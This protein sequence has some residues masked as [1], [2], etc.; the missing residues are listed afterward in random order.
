MLLHG[1]GEGASPIFPVPALDIVEV[2]NNIARKRQL[3]CI[4]EQT[5]QNLAVGGVAEINANMRV[6]DAVF[7]K[8]RVVEGEA[9]VFHIVAHG[10]SVVVKRLS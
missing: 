8:E 7:D 10:E 3:S 1:L 4:L 2:L 9:K 6:K 5:F